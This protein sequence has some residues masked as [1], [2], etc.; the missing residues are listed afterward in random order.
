MFHLAGDGYRSWAHLDVAV[1]VASQ[2]LAVACVQSKRDDIALAEVLI[3]PLH[4]PLGGVPNLHSTVPKMEGICKYS[5][6][7]MR[8]T[9]QRAWAR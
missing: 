5:A 7:Q 3:V 6:G 9:K 2:E 8:G 4:L 1:V